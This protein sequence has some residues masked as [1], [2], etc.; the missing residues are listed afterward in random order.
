MPDKLN[1]ALEAAF[2]EATRRSRERGFQRRVGFGRKPALINVDLANAWTAGQSFTC[3]HMAPVTPGQALP[4][5]QQ[6]PLPIVHVTPYHVTT[7]A[8][9]H[10]HVSWHHKSPVESLPRAS[11][12]CADRLGIAPIAG[13]SADQNRAARSRHYSQA[14]ACSG[15]IPSRDRR[16]ARSG[17]AKP[18]ARP[19]RRLQPIAV[20]QSR[21]DSGRSVESFDID[22]NRRCET[23]ES[24]LQH[25]LESQAFT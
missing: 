24:C 9:R 13:G 17:G 1:E 20:R 10:R 5:R 3:E 16:T 11:G 21:P 15:R 2:A 19:G 22:A 4:A 6:A 23:L 7:A 8:I 25:S 14:S 12:I 18:S